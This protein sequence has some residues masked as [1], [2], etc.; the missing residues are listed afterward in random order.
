M[1][2]MP[3]VLCLL[4]LVATAAAS[5]PYTVQLGEQWIKL[6]VEKL[7]DMGATGRAFASRLER[8]DYLEVRAWRGDL[9]AGPVFVVATDPWIGTVDEQQVREARESL[10]K[11][12]SSLSTGVVKVSSQLAH[13]GDRDGIA[14][15]ATVGGEGTSAQKQMQWRIPSDQRL[16]I[17]TVMGSKAALDQR[18]ADLASLSQ[19]LRVTEP[20]PPPDT[21]G[22]LI[23]FVAGTAALVIGIL[24]LAWHHR[25]QRREVGK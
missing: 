20:P 11:S 12:L 10:E 8:G 6:D 21:W 24:L 15:E 9:A 16:F 5:Q 7:K 19:T 13:F 2:R 17:F 1:S 18:S 3:T 25:R 23:Y 14:M 4:S 22:Y